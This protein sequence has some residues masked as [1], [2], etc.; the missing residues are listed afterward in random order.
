MPNY[1]GSPAMH[2]TTASMA[3]LI[4]VN[5]SELTRAEKAPFENEKAS[6]AVFGKRLFLIISAYEINMCDNVRAET[7]SIINAGRT[8]N[9]TAINLWGA[10]IIAPQAKE[11]LITYSR[12]NTALKGNIKTKLPETHPITSAAA[13]FKSREKN[14]LISVSL[15]PNIKE[16]A[17]NAISKRAA[18]RPEKKNDNTM[19]SAAI[20]LTRMPYI[21]V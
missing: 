14:T 10:F 7:N 13:R 21:S 2:A 3:Q 15:L 18:D 5:E 6:Y 19:N 11:K 8:R 17:S 12:M 9:T 20:K 4:T 1:D 16:A